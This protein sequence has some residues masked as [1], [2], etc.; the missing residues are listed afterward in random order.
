MAGITLAQAQ[1]Q[2]DTWLAAS[3]AVSAKQRYRI[4][5]R[6][7]VYADLAAIQAQ[8]EFWDAKVKSL[9]RGGIRVQYVTPI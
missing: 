6:E 8:I 3:T 5:D 7:L 9:D 1:E 4:G 2:L